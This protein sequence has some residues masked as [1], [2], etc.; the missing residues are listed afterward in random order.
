MVA[1]GDAG[2]V[3]ARKLV[4]AEGG[5][6][7][8]VA[9]P[10]APRVVVARRGVRRVRRHRG[11][12][13]SEPIRPGDAARALDAHVARDSS[14]RLFAERWRTGRVRFVATDRN[15]FISPK[16]QTANMCAAGGH[17]VTHQRHTSSP[18]WH[19]SRA[20]IL[21]GSNARAS[22]LPPRWSR[23]SSPR[24]ARTRRSPLAHA[25]IAAAARRPTGRPRA[26][27]RRRPSPAPRLSVP[28]ASDRQG[29]RCGAPR[30]GAPR[31]SANGRS[32][33]T[34]TSRGG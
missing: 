27:A 14:L 30:G 31:A 24:A 19:F 23:S 18:T 22:V 3:D 6:A 10:L 9:V 5:Y 25:S 16:L 15:L 11:R 20:N 8:A 2:V 12:L 29:R 26:S 33:G 1:V 7:T 28:S 32:T 13:P 4:R 21:G 17:R 34:P